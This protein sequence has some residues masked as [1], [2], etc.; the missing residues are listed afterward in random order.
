MRIQIVM[1]SLSTF[2]LVKISVG[3]LNDYAKRKNQF[4]MIYYLFFKNYFVGGKNNK[5]LRKK[6][7]KR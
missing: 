4:Q 5:K 6:K 7:M 1:P 2:F 3:E